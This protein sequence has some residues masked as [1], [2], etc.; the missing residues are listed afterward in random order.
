MSDAYDAF[1][2]RVE[3]DD[4]YA[5]FSTRVPERKKTLKEQ[6][7]AL[8]KQAK[9]LGHT[10]I[11]EGTPMLKAGAVSGLN[12]LLLGAAPGMTARNEAIGKAISEGNI[13]KAAVKAYGYL[14]S[15]FVAGA[16]VA[17]FDVPDLTSDPEMAARRQELQGALEQSAKDRPIST[18]VGGAAPALIPI[19]GQ[20]SRGLTMGQQMRQGAKVGGLF[21]GLYGLNQA[22]EGQEQMGAAIGTA[23]GAA[24]GAAAPP[25]ITG[26][27]APVMAA[28][29]GIANAA[30]RSDTVRGVLNA[31]DNEFYQRPNSGMSGR[32]NMAIVPT[33][34][35]RSR[36]GR[37]A[38]QFV[39]PNDAAV[40]VARLADR[41]GID[42]PT[43]EA[44]IQ[45][46]QAD[47]RGR[48]L[49]ELLGQPGVQ[50]AA[51][52]SRMPGQTGELAQRQLG[53][54]NRASGQRLLEELSGAP[55]Q[56]PVQVLSERVQSTAVQFLRPLFGPRPDNAPAAQSQ[57]ALQR[58]AQRESI[59]EALPMAQRSIQELIQ[60]G[61][62]PPD[63]IN[64]PAY[65]LH[66]AKMALSRM[67]KDPTTV[68]AGKPRLDNMFLTRAQKD[69]T[70]ALE[71]IRP[72]YARAMEELEKVIRPREVAQDIANMRGVAPNVGNR[73]L[74]DPETRR[75]LGQ[76]GLENFGQSLQT[77]A[78]MFAN[79]SR[80]M[81]TTNSIT[82]PVSMGAA[83][84]MAMGMQRMP[85]SIPDM[86]NSALSYFAQ[87][88]NEN[89]RNERGRF[90]L[91]IIDDPAS[92]L[93]PQER[94]AIANEMMRIARERAAQTAVSMSGTRG[95]TA[96]GAGLMGETGQ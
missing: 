74:S 58:L 35:P 66:Y 24:F 3:D 80:M 20:A 52:I 45:T 23:G 48:T 91:R 22:P 78:E 86:I 81:P 55:G 38:P 56:D 28:G 84:E 71:D 41:A 25:I 88:V 87:G 12:T 37:A 27:A 34:P 75:Q 36:P 5:S 59:S 15:P 39:P 17:G 65:L 21:G 19:Y 40:R 96:G 29:R 85:T 11:T 43:L 13:P 42:L 95:A 51:T 62:L 54:R 6:A 31:I 93:S 57:A 94:Q 7:K 9:A 82:A 2:T 46:A 76:P 63:A 64:D 47:P 72:G 79:A 69:I 92:G 30:L 90:L 33:L 77:E 26:L 32:V 89:I 83:D 70:A 60:L 53:E 14:S 61:D 16:R 68:Q 18:F 44:R 1:S 4:P 8:V 73:L 50:S 67:I 49:A 10:V